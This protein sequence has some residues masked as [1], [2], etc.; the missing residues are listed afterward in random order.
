MQN[1]S[2]QKRLRPVKVIE[3]LHIE[4]PHL[5]LITDD[6]Q[7]GTVDSWRVRND[8][9]IL[10]TCDEDNHQTIINNLKT[11]VGATITKIDVKYSDILFEF[12]D[13]RVLEV[14]VTSPFDAWTLRFK[15]MVF[16]PET[17]Y[18]TEEQLKMFGVE[19]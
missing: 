15:D 12:E 1:T 14:F 13:G 4:A 5:S 9:K 8:E 6:W 19:E 3:V 17:Y 10:F 11:I 2:F 16:I 7:F 18:S